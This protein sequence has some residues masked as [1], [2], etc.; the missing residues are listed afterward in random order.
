[1]PKLYFLALVILVTGCA[2]TNPLSETADHRAPASAAL[3]SIKTARVP[4]SLPVGEVWVNERASTVCYLISRNNSYES[5]VKVRSPRPGPVE[6][7]E[8]ASQFSTHEEWL[9]PG[10][11]V[12]CSVMAR[13][14]AMID[15]H[16]DDN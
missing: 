2:S 1:M 12:T 13:E 6:V 7:R 4:T 15:C 16:T 11:R 9:D 3:S 5:C 10:N 8:V 14:T